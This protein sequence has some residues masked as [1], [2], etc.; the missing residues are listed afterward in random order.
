[1]KVIILG[2]TGITGKQLVEQALELKHTVTVLVRNPS[3]LPNGGEGVNVIAG[4]VLDKKVLTDAIK[5]QDAVISALGIGNSFNP[6]HFITNAVN[7]LIPAMHDA[8]VK[9]L[10]FLSA[11]G[12]GK[13]Y[14]QA[15]ILLKIFFRTLLKDVYADKA[16]ADEHIRGSDLDW[17]IVMPTKLT[18]GKRTG[19]HQA[20]EDLTVGNFATISRADVAEFMLQQLT[21]TTFLR[22]EPVVT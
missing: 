12:V 22:K 9:R 8:G 5:G 10:I 20:A 14:N 16:V 18:D 21:D 11:F 1:M 7:I 13:T 15:G 2:A 19:R 3:K 6:D 17:T 4:S